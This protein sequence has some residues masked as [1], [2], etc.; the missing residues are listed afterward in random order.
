MNRRIDFF[1]PKGDENTVA[2]ITEQ[3]KGLPVVRAIFVEDI[4]SLP[5]TQT[6]QT[7]A[8]KAKAD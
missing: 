5:S 1:L 7:I 4:E 6:M 8:T 3:V 2:S